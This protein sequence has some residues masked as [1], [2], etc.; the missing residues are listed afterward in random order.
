MRGQAP[1][2]RAC[3]RAPRAASRS[4]RTDPS[5]R[6]RPPPPQLAAAPR[7]PPPMWWHESW[8]QWRCRLHEIGRA[9]ARPGVRRLS[10]S[11]PGWYRPPSC[12]AHACCAARA[13]YLLGCSHRSMG[14]SAG[15]MPVASS[16]APRFAPGS[17]AAR[18]APGS[19]AA[20]FAPGSLAA[21]L[22]DVSR[23]AHHPQAA[24]WRASACE[25]PAVPGHVTHAAARAGDT[26]GT[27]GKSTGAAGPWPTWSTR[28]TA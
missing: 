23:M 18:F 13:S 10:R 24:G 22:R 1:S 11:P 17:L 3:E 2:C 16:K 4:P 27:R 6:R 5:T 19:L 20:R 8:Q 25:G 7:A 12:P 28:P 14:D 26:F 15:S 21:R 9:L